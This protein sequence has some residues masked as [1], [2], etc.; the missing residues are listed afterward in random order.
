MTTR[1]YIKSIKFTPNW[2]SYPCIKGW[3]IAIRT[4]STETDSDV[5]FIKGEDSFRCVLQSKY[6]GNH[7][8]EFPSLHFYLDKVLSSAVSDGAGEFKMKTE[9]LNDIVECVRLLT[10]NQSLTIFLHSAVCSNLQGDN[11]IVI[12]WDIEELGEKE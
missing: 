12:D 11:E 6:G 10:V 9:A 4:S 3:D 1:T 8:A 2:E 5:H 7:V